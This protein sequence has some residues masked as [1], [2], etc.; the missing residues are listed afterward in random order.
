[1][2]ALTLLMNELLKKLTEKIANLSNNHK[3]P[4]KNPQIRNMILP[5]NAITNICAVLENVHGK[6]SYG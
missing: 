6:Y 2:R 3:G 4:K 1:M 5:M